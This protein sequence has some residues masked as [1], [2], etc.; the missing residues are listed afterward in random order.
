MRSLSRLSKQIRYY[1]NRNYQVKVV[2]YSHYPVDIRYLFVMANFFVFVLLSGLA[3]ESV[4]GNV[5]AAV[6]V[7]LATLNRAIHFYQLDRD[8]F[9]AEQQIAEI[10]ELNKLYD[11]PAKEKEGSDDD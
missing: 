8:I 1:L 10:K 6:A 11:L 3:G 7:T 9:V 4:A 2:N 5:G